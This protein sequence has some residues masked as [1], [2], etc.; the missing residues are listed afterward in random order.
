MISDVV[1]RYDVDSQGRFVESYIS[2]V[3]DRLLGVP[4][5]TI[6]NSFDAYFSYV[7]PEDLPYVREMLGKVLRTREMF[8]EY[9]LRKPDGATLWV[10]SKGSAHPQPDGHIAAFGTTSDI[11]Q[12]KRLLDEVALRERQLKSFFQGA[13]AGLA[14]LDKDMRYVQLNRTLAE[15]NGI[16]VE[17]H[18]DRILREVVPQLAPQLEPI[19]RKVLTSGEPVLDVEITGETP[20]QPGVQRHWM[21][22]F[23]PVAGADGGPS[24]VGTIVVE[25]TER[26]R[27]ELRIQHLI[28]VLRAVRD[29]GDLIVRERNADRLLSE[30][31]KTLMRTRGYRLAWIGGVVPGSQRVVPLASAGPAVD[32][33]QDVT[34]TW[35]ECET[36]RGPLGTALRERKTTVCQDTVAD[37]RFALWLKPAL[38]R[39]YRSVAAV[40]MVHD[41]RLF[42]AVAVY[43]DQPAAFGNEELELLAKLASDLASALQAIEAE[44]ERKQAEQSL[45][46]AKIAAEAANRAKSEFLANMSH[47]IRTPMTAVLGF[48]DLLAAN[49][50]SHDERHQ[51]LAGMRRNGMALLDLINNIL[52]FSRIEADKLTLERTDNPIGQIIDDVMSTVTPSVVKKGLSLVVDYRW[53]LPETIHTDPTRLR[54]ILVNLVSNAVKFT[55]QGEVRIAVRCRHDDDGSTRVQFAVSDTGIG[56][57]TGKIGQ[58]FRPFMQVDGSASRRYGGTGLGLVISQRLATALGGDIGVVSELGKG[59]TF[60]LTTDAG[61]LRGVRMLQS[62]EL[63]VVPGEGSSSA[64][65]E[66]ML[67]GRVLLAED[68]PDVHLVLGCVLR[69]FNLQVEIAQDG[70]VACEMAAKS[71][72]EGKPYDLILMDIQMPRLNGYEATRWL[73]RH[74]WQGPI[75][76]LTAHAIVGDREKCLEAGCN[77]YLS[78]PVNAKELWDVLGRHLNRV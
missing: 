76:A 30:A 4:T 11:T 34:I 25:T 42:G 26:K 68:V 57:P 64:E 41:G 35:D 55:E 48:G 38:A 52:D 65:Q 44:Q 54:Q 71:K 51:Y 2:P 45:V 19:F 24:A 78:K 40:P 73:R 37:P 62:P 58:L 46:H 29:I 6:G 18:I 10:R 74:G 70:F 31:C 21:A 47:E 15:I 33:L 27:A 7:V 43:A 69:K 9:R 28:E 56:I 53:P 59:S 77:D 23:F 67:H 1:W 20:D 72:A 60:T 5:G 39:G 49:N 61:P 22:S 50:L 14:L 16:S 66:P 75:V 12:G 13:T 32:Y 17:Q 8:V 36:G 3:A 63:A